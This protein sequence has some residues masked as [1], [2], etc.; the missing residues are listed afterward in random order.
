MAVRGL[1]VF[2]FG[3]VFVASALPVSAHC[4][5]CT[6]AV[7]AGVAVSR[8]YGVD[9]SIV[10][11]WIG[12]FVI[13]TALWFNRMLKKNYLP[14]QNVIVGLAALLLTVVPFYFAGLI[15]GLHAPQLFGI[16]RL[17]FGILLGSVLTYAAIFGSNAIKKR[18]G[19]VIIPYQTVLLT[20]ATLSGTST[21]LWLTLSVF[22]VVL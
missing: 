8:F 3:L 10:G 19:R 12:A 5:L 7:G 13:S 2:I 14:M 17:L 11:L 20:L 15:G 9:D 1:S 16:D 18:R 6:G 21:V 4:P 22:K